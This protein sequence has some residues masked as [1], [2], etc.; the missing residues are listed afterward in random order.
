MTTRR[1]LVVAVASSAV[2]MGLASVASADISL[3]WKVHDKTST[4]DAT[5]KVWH[6]EGNSRINADD[7]GAQAKDVACPVTFKAAS[8]SRGWTYA[9]GDDVIDNDAELFK[10]FE[11]ISPG[12]S[13]AMTKWDSTPGVSYNKMII[14]F[15][16]PDASTM[17]HEVGHVAGLSHL[18]I[19]KR[20]MTP[21]NS[22]VLAP[23]GPKSR[24]RVDQPECDAYK[25]LN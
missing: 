3:K 14:V 5:V 17:V 4:S 18:S 7:D 2:A 10:A 19:A 22:P 12:N 6:T 24:T 8:I 1:W 11:G 9:G 23:D 13:A 15:A 25:T 21:S 20:F 16:S